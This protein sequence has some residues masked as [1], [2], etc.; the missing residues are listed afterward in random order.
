VDVEKPY[1]SA[2]AESTRVKYSPRNPDQGAIA[3]SSIDRS[4]S[5][6]SSSGSTWN[7]VPRPSHVSHAPYGELNEKLRGASSSN[8]RPQCMHARCSENTSVS[9]S[10]SE[11]PFG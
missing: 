4:S 8:D 10:A 5:G 6:T 3:P 11:S 7:L 1:S 2:T 9:G